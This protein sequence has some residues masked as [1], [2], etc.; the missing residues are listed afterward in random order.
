[1]GPVVQGVLLFSLLLRSSSSRLVRREITDNDLDIYSF[2][3][4][5][6]VSSRYAVTVI[7]SR[8]ANRASEPREVN[9]H[10][11][12]PKYAFISKFNMTI[13]GKS[14][15]G[16][17]KKKEEAQQQYSQAV[18]RG[19]SAGLVSAVG[20]TLEEFKTSVTVAA[21]SKVTFELTYEELLKRRLGKY[22]L[23]I[24]AQPT[25]VV[26]DFKIDVHIIER[27]GIRFLETQGGL[28]SN[29]LASAVSTNVTDKEALVHFS[30]SHEQQQCPHCKDMGL[31]G[32]LIV[33]YDVNRPKSQGELQVVN[34]YFVHYFAP[35]SLSRFPKN[36]VFIIDQSG[37]M[38]G[39]KI[40]QTRE[41]MLKILDDLHKE[42]HFGLITFDG[43]VTYWKDNLV[44]V[45][46]DYLALAR[47]FVE[48]IKSRGSTD[49]NEAVLK[50][51]QML[52]IFDESHPQEESTSILILLTDGDPT[53]GV[54]NLNEIQN[55]VREA[56]R[57]RYTLYCLGF[58]FDVDYKFLEKISLQN[59]GLARRIYEDSDAALQLQGFYEE[60]ATPLLLDVQM[61][62]TGVSNVTYTSF[63][64]YYDGSEIVVAGQINH[65]DLETFTAEVKAKTKGNDSVFHEVFTKSER[66]ASKAL[67]H[68]IFETY[69]QRLWA[70]L[71]VQQLLERLV[72]LTEEQQTAVNEQILARS[73]DY[74][75]VTP[76]TSMVVTKPEGEDPHVAHKPKE[77]K[78]LER[79]FP[80]SKTA[81]RR[82]YSRLRI[83]SRPL[84][85]GPHPSIH[86][87]HGK[88]RSHPVMQEA[89]L[90]IARVIA[91][92]PVQTSRYQH[93]AESVTAAEPVQTSG[94]QHIAESVTAA[95]P[96]QTS[97][98]L[99]VLLPAQDQNTSIC[100]NIEVHKDVLPKD[101][102]F[103]LLH[104]P[105]TGI[106][107]NGE[108]LKRGHF[109]K[110][111]VNYKDECHIKADTTG[112]MVT[113]EGKENFIFW[114]DTATSHHCDGVTISLQ[115][116]VL[117]VSV[118]DISVNILL[119]KNG[120][121]RFLW[122][123]VRRQA[124]IPGAKGLLGQSPVSYVLKEASP[125]VRLE[126]LGKEVQGTR[127]TTVDYRTHVKPTVD[128][129]LVPFSAVVPEPLS[130]ILGSL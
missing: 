104:D 91:A 100:F 57:K 83:S 16:V 70:Y 11:E 49:I 46:S 25:Q 115:N 64:Q 87:N 93:I 24:K 43:E 111:G 17:V 116:E 65:N 103:K 92:E 39:T 61:H 82:T 75:F 54:T 51:V 63:G 89:D 32:E 76:L 36:V 48:N 72:L 106:S 114:T 81:G 52:S 41:A 80:V 88:S 67:D 78:P 38:R 53:S 99:K 47:I 102:V 108:M 96:V 107:I 28:A 109:R 10:V 79:A 125:L 126:M 74:S 7:T 69:I 2:H 27:Q 42:D 90:R 127:D 117:N 19:E 56:I 71:S 77:E 130:E 112:I 50:G 121:N 35:S 95:E 26:K 73:L 29:D 58:G 31:S 122:P 6:V 34:G 4:K 23:R 98:L 21:H 62:Y 3:I 86:G 1:M 105:A 14:Y 59:N 20:R 37:S 12:L 40:Q 101:P 94:Y 15:S 110:I 33:V 60:V 120:R 97:V 123:D 45:N 124:P 8:V 85:T 55:N 66:D 18:S 118:G 68:Y 84:P 30:P 119:H 113:K 128:C 5:S 129:W 9:F 22:E 44:P 13:D